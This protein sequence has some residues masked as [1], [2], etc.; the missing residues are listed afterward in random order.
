MLEIIHP[1]PLPTK[2][3]R[4]NFEARILQLK[5]DVH[6][7]INKKKIEKKTDNSD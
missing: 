2:L 3:H 5:V 1:H 7:H 6:I 4:Q